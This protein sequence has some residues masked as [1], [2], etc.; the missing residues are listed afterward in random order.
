ME[1]KANMRMLTALTLASVCRANNNPWDPS[2]LAKEQSKAVCTDNL[3]P[4]CNTDW[5][6]ASSA[7]AHCKM[8]Q[9]QTCSFCD[10]LALLKSIAG[11]SPVDS[12]DANMLTCQTWCSEVR[13]H[14]HP[15]IY[16]M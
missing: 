8:C 6:S 16:Y 3:Q 12:K 7:D 10:A 5:C 13:I 11:C 1:L 15:C 4:S 9:C 2:N 14:S